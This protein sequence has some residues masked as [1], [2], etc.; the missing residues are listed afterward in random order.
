MFTKRPNGLHLGCSS[1]IIIVIVLDV[2]EE[3]VGFELVKL[4]SNVVF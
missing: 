1:Q 2:D 3:D 4:S